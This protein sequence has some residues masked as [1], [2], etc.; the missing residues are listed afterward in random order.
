MDGLTLNL[1]NV[2]DFKLTSLMCV[3]SGTG[4]DETQS[5]FGTKKKTQAATRMWLER[6]KKVTL[7]RFFDLLGSFTIGISLSSNT[8]AAAGRQGRWG[9]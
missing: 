1:I 8:L 2:S 5:Y 3:T 9:Q 7:V 4:L 6:L